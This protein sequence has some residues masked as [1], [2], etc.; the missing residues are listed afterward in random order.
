MQLKGQ[1]KTVR[2]LLEASGFGWDPE[3]CKVTTPDDVWDCYIESH[4]NAA[5]FHDNPFPLYDD[6]D[7]LCQGTISSG[8]VAFNTGKCRA[9]TPNPDHSSSSSESGSDGGGGEGEAA[10]SSKK[11]AKDSSSSKES[12]E[13][14]RKK[15]KL[16]SIATSLADGDSSTGHESRRGHNA[17]STSN[18][19]GHCKCTSIQG[20]LDNIALSLGDI[21]DVLAEPEKE[22]TPIG[23]PATI[24]EDSEDKLAVAIRLLEADTMLATEDAAIAIDMFISNLQA[25]KAYML[26]STTQMHS[27][28]ICHRIAEK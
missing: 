11:K 1:Y 4:S 27:F 17:S 19:H 22:L 21:K 26:I 15:S 7:H 8:S 14:T 13:P 20:T 28:W 16:S 18:S 24:K 25:A 2:N 5:Y 10:K 9:P 23:V 12:S 6:L 3:K